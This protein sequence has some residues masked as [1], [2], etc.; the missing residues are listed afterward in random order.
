M[1]KTPGSNLTIATTTTT[2]ITTFNPVTTKSK[3]RNFLVKGDEREDISILQAR[4]R[5]AG[6]YY[7]N[8]T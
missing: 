5:I 8:P 1:A 2:K 4:L 6:F 3:S 7:G